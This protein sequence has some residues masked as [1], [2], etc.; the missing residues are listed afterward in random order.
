MATVS[1]QENAV[2]IEGRIS[3]TLEEDQVIQDLSFDFETD[4]G[5]W[6]AD[7]FEPTTLHGRFS[8]SPRARSGQSLGVGHVDC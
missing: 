7:G 3:L 4:L 5:G 6:T 8:S 1:S 2:P